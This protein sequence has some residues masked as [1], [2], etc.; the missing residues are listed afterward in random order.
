MKN[1][2]LSKILTSTYQ[3]IQ[4]QKKNIPLLSF[5]KKIEKSRISFKDHLKK[6]HPAFILECKQ[7][8]P[9]NGIIN[10]KFNISKIINVYDKYADIISVITEEKF[11]HGNF[12]YLLQ[13]RENT[14]KPLLCK[15]FFIDPYQIYYARYH[16]ANAI[17]LMLSILDDATYMKL[18]NIAKQMHL[19]VLTE[20][21]NIEELKRALALNAEVIGINNR[22]LKDLSVDIHKTKKIAQLIPKDRIIICESGITSYTDVRDLSKVVDGFLIGSHL[23]KSKNLESAT[24]SIIYGENKICGL[25]NPLE[26]QYAE[27]YGCVYGGLNFIPKSPRYIYNQEAKEI[28]TYTKL[29][30]IGIFRNE[31]HQYILNKVDQFNLYAVQL[32]G[33]EDDI[34]IKKLKRILPKSVRIWKAISMKKDTVIKTNSNINRYLLDNQAGGTGQTFDWRL[35]KTFK[36]ADMMLAGGLNL[37]NSFLASTLGFR[38]LDFN[39][40]LE[41]SPGRKDP[42]KI[43]SIFRILRF[44]KKNKK[45]LH[46]L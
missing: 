6:N 24:R 10:K 44:Y 25:K 8:S 22:N 23:M 3:W 27:K 19:G 7:S 36:I 4:Y 46:L 13:A 9:S 34:F 5:E 1:N 33:T 37:K 31:S 2:I 20:I 28:V 21:N 32:H 41:L 45:L 40:G 17:L 26:A 38:G 12:E 15:D 11:F 18:S 43:K 35:I 39:T 42:K 30:Y 14:K 29:K 16:K